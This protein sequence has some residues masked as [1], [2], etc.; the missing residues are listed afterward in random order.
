MRIFEY[1]S[2]SISVIGISIIVWGIAVTFLRFIKCEYDRMKYKRRMYMQREIL[3]HTFGTYLLLALEFLIAADLIL[4]VID[5]SFY[6]L[7]ILGGIVVIRTVISFF[8]DR[9]NEETR[10]YRE[11]LEKKTE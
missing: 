6:D 10:E 11:R 5:F 9:E 8:L 7:G 1:I 3:R 4:T 2:F